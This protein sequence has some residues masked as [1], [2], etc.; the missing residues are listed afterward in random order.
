MKILKNS[1]YCFKVRLLLINL[2]KIIIDEIRTYCECFLLNWYCVSRNLLT[3]WNLT[4]SSP[5]G[6]KL[7][8]I[9]K[10]LEDL[11]IKKSFFIK[12]WINKLRLSSKLC[13]WVIL[14]RTYPIIQKSRRMYFWKRG[15]SNFPSSHKTL[16]FHVFKP[17]LFL[18][19]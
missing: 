4:S 19:D 5:P 18:E 1:K 12:L 7:F 3:I 2:Y 17:F 14:A 9:T 8:N 13:V 11:T 15:C 10:I 6:K 16:T